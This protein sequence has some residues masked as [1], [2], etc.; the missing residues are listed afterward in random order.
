MVLPGRITPQPLKGLLGELWLRKAITDNEHKQ[1]SKYRNL[2]LKTGNQT[3]IAKRLSSKF[4]GT[5]LRSTGAVEPAPRPGLTWGQSG[6]AKDL[7]GVRTPRFFRAVLFGP[8]L[9]SVFIMYFHHFRTKTTCLQNLKKMAV[10]Y[11]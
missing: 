9:Y 4:Y 8:Q 5:V 2:E 6:P 7:F 1:N 3:R 10:L 11:Y